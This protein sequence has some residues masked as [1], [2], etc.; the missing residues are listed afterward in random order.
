MIAEPFGPVVPAVPLPGAPLVFVVAQARFERIASIVAEEFIA[1]FQEAI[2]GSYPRMRRELETHRAV[3]L[4][5][6]RPVALDEILVGDARV[7]LHERGQYG[8]PARRC[9]RCSPCA[10]LDHVAGGEVFQ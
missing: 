5:G 10:E 4:S 3:A 6:S 2:R 1:A 7:E 8:R 9:G